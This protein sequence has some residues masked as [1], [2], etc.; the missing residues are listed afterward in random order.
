MF[1][2]C[3]K[4]MTVKI[5]Q[6]GDS[7][8]A[9]CGKRRYLAEGA[10]YETAT[11]ERRMFSNF[12]P[13]IKES[14]DQKSIRFDYG[15]FVATVSLPGEEPE[16]NFEIIGTETSDHIKAI[17]WPG[18]IRREFSPSGAT[19]LPIMQGMLLR[20]T[21]KK[22]YNIMEGQFYT[23]EGTMPW[24]GQYDEDSA[25]FARVITPFDA[26]YR[27]CHDIGT[28]TSV[29]IHW[30]PSL[31]SF[32]TSRRMQ[33][34]FFDTPCDYVVFARH[35]RALLEREGEIVTLKQKA[36]KNP[37]LERLIGSPVYNGPLIYYQIE[38]ES[39]YYNHENKEKNTAL[40]T[41]DKACDMIRAQKAKGVEKAYI[42]IDGWGLGGY[43]NLCPRVLPPCP[44]AGGTEGLR[45]VKETCREL[46]YLLAYHDQYRDFYYISPDFDPQKA[47]T[48]EGGSITSK[49]EIV[50]Y[51]GKEAQLCAKEALAFV[52]RNYGQMQEEGICPDGAYLDVFSAS[53]LDECFHEKHRMTR[54]ECAKARGACF[55]FIR[56]NQMIVSS[57]EI[58]G[59]FVKHLDLVHHSPY[60]GW[61]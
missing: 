58:M 8:T 32:R 10:Y 59:C 36:E 44:K 56:E 27:Y 39:S 14:H 52:K 42:H 34:R 9:V 1:T 38:P 54:E 61:D 50:W 12:T 51:G 26:Q 16:L 19:V 6:S 48:H 17:C 28:A 7:F 29:S 22:A 23:R 11:G 31:G 3:N 40:V 41:F 53:D 15:W 46:D 21:E 25:Y 24:W 47:V 13:K 49:E 35:Y 20:D 55:D 4:A 60:I 43:D 5:S 33:I 57:E 30:I 2:I 18:A 45:R 37:T